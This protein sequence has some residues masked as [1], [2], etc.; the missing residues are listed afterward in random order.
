MLVT[1]TTGMATR[2]AG[3]GRSG[4]RTFRAK[5]GTEVHD[6]FFE[7]PFDVKEAFGKA[8]AP[9]KVTVNGH[10]YRSTV[11]THQGRYY[12]PVNR[13]HRAAAG[14]ESGD[15]LRVV[16]ELDTEPRAVEPP[17]ELAAAL[18]RNP[19]ARAAWDQLSFSHQK[20]HAEAILGAKRP[21]T[22]ERRVGK[23]IAM[24]QAGPGRTPRS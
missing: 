14:V 24:L 13:L 23:A 4:R 5:L 1:A 15:L 2:G 7:V 11:S 3:P 12:V 10:A 19:T 20:E 17:P 21:E 18:A 6:L 8:R 16:L 9:V 22:R